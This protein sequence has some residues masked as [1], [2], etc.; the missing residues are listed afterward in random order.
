MGDDYPDGS[1]FQDYH[2]FYSN[3]LIFS[4]FYLVEREEFDYVVT[5]LRYNELLIVGHPEV[6]NNQYTLP[7]FWSAAA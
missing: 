1:G 3:V 7:P 5:Q 6:Y 2:D 4:Y